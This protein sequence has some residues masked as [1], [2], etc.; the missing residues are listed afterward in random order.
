MADKAAARFTFDERIMTLLAKTQLDVRSL[1]RR[2]SDPV[3]YAFVRVALLDS[4]VYS[5][6]QAHPAYRQHRI[7]VLML[8]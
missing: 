4:A 8:R 7:H 1:C 3:H 5:S 2:A 6:G